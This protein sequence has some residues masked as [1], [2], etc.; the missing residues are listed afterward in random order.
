MHPY[1]HILEQHGAVKRATD[2]EQALESVKKAAGF[3]IPADYQHFL[4]NYAGFEGA[5]GEQYLRLEDVDEV[6]ETNEGYEV[7]QHL[8]RT[9]MIGSNGGGEFIAIVYMTD[10]Q[11]YKVV[12]SPFVD[13]DERYHVWIGNTFSDFLVRLEKGIG[14]F[15]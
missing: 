15:D 6:L 12:L 14:W 1:E 2:P 7:Q 9:L 13:M 4:R 8:P 11:G 10:T 3:P 5:I